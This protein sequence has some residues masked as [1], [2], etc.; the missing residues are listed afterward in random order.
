MN[1]VSVCFRN[2]LSIV[3]N[4]YLSFNLYSKISLLSCETWIQVFWDVIFFPWASI[5]LLFAG[6]F[7]ETSGY[8]RPTAQCY[9]LED[10]ELHQH[11]FENVISHSGTHFILNGR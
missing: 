6:R 8:T 9:F 5:C 3:D 7:F 10:M 4:E 11:L 1:C 2:V